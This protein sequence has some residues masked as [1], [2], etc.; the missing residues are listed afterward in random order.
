MR[1]IAATFIRVSVLEKTDSQTKYIVSIVI[2]NIE[3]KEIIFVSNIYCLA[4]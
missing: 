4:M 1:N 3:P 2:I